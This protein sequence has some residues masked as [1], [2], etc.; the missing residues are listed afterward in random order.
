MRM[1]QLSWNIM[2]YKLLTQWT[3]MRTIRDIKAWG[4]IYESLQYAN[5]KHFEFL[6]EWIEFFRH[7]FSFT[8]INFLN[9]ISFRDEFNLL[10][11]FYRK[12]KPNGINS[13]QSFVF[14]E[15]EM[16]SN[17]RHKKVTWASWVG[18]KSILWK[19]RKQ[20]SIEYKKV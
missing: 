12:K 8:E 5:S 19:Q 15:F 18:R 11:L 4:E 7:T 17:F 13:S 3:A 1:K 20:L 9:S 16:N 14:N 6:Q 2:V 10:Q